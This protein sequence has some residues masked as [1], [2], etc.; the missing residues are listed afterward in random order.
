MGRC[1][2]A[3]IGGTLAKLVFFEQK[4]TTVFM[5]R[6]RSNSHDMAANEMREFLVDATNYGRTGVRESRLK[7]E[8]ERLGGVRGMTDRRHTCK[9]R[10]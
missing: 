4:S 3:D 6:P 7:I 9:T 8:L 2:G 10:S 5:R 1:F